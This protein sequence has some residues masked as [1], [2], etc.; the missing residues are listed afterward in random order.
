MEGNAM[1]ERIK[2]LAA[3]AGFVLW[4]DEEWNP[5]DV[6]DWASRYDNELVK[7]TQ[8]LVNEVLRLQAEGTD[9]ANYYGVNPAPAME[10]IELDFSDEELLQY[11]KLAH[12][13][14][15]TFNKLVENALRAAIEATGVEDE[16]TTA[17]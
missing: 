5:G 2:E 7:Y 1:N 8:L 9:V 4:D 11:M 17:S 15:I 14:D 16:I 3:R 12:E 10:G 13:Q 6:V